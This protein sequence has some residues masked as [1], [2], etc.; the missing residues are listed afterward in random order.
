MTLAL[1]ALGVFLQAAAPAPNSSLADSTTAND[2]GRQVAPVLFFPEPGMDDT[3][4]YQGYATR[5]Y[6]DSKSNTV[7]I[8]LDRRS[9]REVLLWA[10]ALNESAAFTARDARGRA[11]RLDWDSEQATVSDTGG[12]RTITYRL[13]VAAPSVTLGWFVLG[14]MRIERDFQYAHGHLRPFS[15]PPY[16]VSP[17]SLLVANLA[18][19][20]AAEQRE[21]LSLLRASSVAELRSRLTPTINSRSSASS[22]TVRISRPALDGKSHLSLELIGA[23]R[24]ASARVLGRTVSIR[25]RT[26]SV[27]HLTIRVTTDGTALTPLARDEIFSPGFLSFL[28][29][30]KT[31]DSADRAR[32]L[33]REVRSVELLSSNEKLM[34]GL[35]NYATYFGRDG[36]M[37]AL[38]MRSIWTPV[39]SERVI[40][41]VLG[42]L[43]PTGDV[44]HEEALGEQAI[45]EHADEYNATM[46][47][48]F[49]RSRS[50]DRA[51]ADS[52][53][54]AARGILR[55][56]RRTR[57][58]YHM[59]DDEFQL[60]VLEALYLADSTVPAERKRTFLRA[61]ASNGESHL[62]LMLREMALVATETQAFA[63]DPIATNLVSFVRRDSTHWQSASWR[64]SDVGYANGRFA[65]DI[66]AIWAPRALQAI[67]SALSSLRALGYSSEALDSV[68]PE[69]ARSPLGVWL[70]DSMPLVRA[71]ESWQR[72]RRLFVV[73]L[74][75]REVERRIRAKL[76]S[77]PAAERRYWEKTMTQRKVS[78]DSVVFLALSLDARGV[79]IPVVNTDPATDLFLRNH[80]IRD[81]RGQGT[82]GEVLREIEPFLRYYPVGLFVDTLGPVV[83]N[84]AY[85]S[86]EVWRMFE[87]DLYHSPR[88]VWGREVNLFLLGTADQ[89]SAAL[90]STG[91]V[92]DPSLVP[93]V[94]SLRSSLERVLLAVTASHLQHNEVW[95][96]RI[97][98]GRLLPTRYGTSSDV[99][100]WSTTDLAVQYALS[101]LGMR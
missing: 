65:M 96:Y 72:A 18:R 21:Q 38:M 56:L 27:V 49:G 46:K 51:R 70:G 1:L 37:T 97:S 81:T 25:A 98:D 9:G 57:E 10:D 101:R 91:H 19:L 68:T 92:A 89:I 69:I 36:M 11:A 77:L 55:E 23:P 2:A 15:A 71:I 75:P 43:A 85:A 53:L 94:S 5:F 31:S 28:S 22:W 83:A 82:S 30:S 86:S 80:A 93:Y 76:A 42:K 16:V 12:D 14:T 73:A 87:K 62:T 40:A 61:T 100:L 4:A 35:P 26:G 59:M 99:Q 84:D 29:A 74:G 44:S 20:P 78:E 64:D 63:Q 90:D 47:D 45:R 41:S 13:Q 34:A 67:A 8:Y 17:E 24:H 54:A 79:P 52:D 3:A 39:M 66:N 7:Q 95:S 48:Y 6:R 50:G 32:R 60:P 58:N 88:V 33:E